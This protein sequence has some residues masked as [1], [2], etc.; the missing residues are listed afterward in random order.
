MQA[1]ANKMRRKKKKEH[2][3]ETERWNENRDSKLKCDERL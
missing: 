1:V 3:R 2:K